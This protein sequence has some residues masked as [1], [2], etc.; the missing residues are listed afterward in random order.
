MSHLKVV[1]NWLRS[2]IHILSIKL[3]VNCE[4][5][6]SIRLRT[7]FFTSVYHFVRHWPPDSSLRSMVHQTFQP[8]FQIKRPGGRRITILLSKLQFSKPL[9]GHTKH[10]LVRRQGWCLA[11][12]VLHIRIMLVQKYLHMNQC[13]FPNFPNE[14][15][16]VQGWKESTIALLIDPSCSSVQASAHAVKTKALWISINGLIVGLFNNY[17]RWTVTEIHKLLKRNCLTNGQA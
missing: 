8:L 14:F 1:R 16:T 12:H 15:C 9:W 2:V 7:L 6:T 13:A 4:Q 11:W 17:Y 5:R 3:L 10:Q